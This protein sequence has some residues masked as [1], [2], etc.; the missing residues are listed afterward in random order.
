MSHRVR[1]FFFR[2]EKALRLQIFDDKRARFLARKP[3][4]FF[5]NIFV[6]RAVGIQNIDDFQ[7][8]PLAHLP[9]VRI[10]SRRNFHHSSSEFLVNIRVG[11]E[12]NYPSC[13]RKTQFFSD[14]IF[15]AFVFGIHRHSRIA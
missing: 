13:E 5:G 7:I 15:V 9:V 6:E 1:D 12:R 3:A 2:L 11:D 4:I 14:D 8:V 10:V